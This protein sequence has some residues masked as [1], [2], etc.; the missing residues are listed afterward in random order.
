VISVG[1]VSMGGSGKSPLV[2]HVARLLLDMGE[3]PSVLSRGYAR[4]RPMD[5]A[6]V[7][8]DGA[9]ILASYDQAGDEPLMLARQLPGCAVV[10][11]PDR[12]L[13]GSLAERRLGCTVHVLDDGFQHVQLARALDLVIV[14]RTDLDDRV[15]PL[16]RLRE[17]LAAIAAAD[18]VVVDVAEDLDD[19]PLVGMGARRIFT[20]TRSVGAPRQEPAF[21]FAGIGRPAEFFEALRQNGWTLVGSRPFPDHHRYSTAELTRLADEGKAAGAEL[22]VTTEK[23]AARIQDQPRVLPL[24]AV[25]LTLSVE[26]A[27]QFAGVLA[28]AIRGA[29][30]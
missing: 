17:P 29:A 3:K 13:A 4:P 20:M 25:P 16:G 9:Q 14:R 7:V 19:A 24:L 15:M 30:R 26:P 2:A 5:G 28:Q 11:C 22:L 27:G 21:A 18:A 8:S 10:V 12:Y 1:N 23:D 6:V